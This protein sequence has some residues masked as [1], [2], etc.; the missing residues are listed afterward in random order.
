M[1]DGDKVT[2]RTHDKFNGKAGTVEFIAGFYTDGT[3]RT[4]AVTVEGKRRYFYIW[5]LN[6]NAT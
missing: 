3:P 4:Y 1:K 2:I 6:K 5:E